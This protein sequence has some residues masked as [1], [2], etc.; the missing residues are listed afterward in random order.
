MLMDLAKETHNILRE[1]S[2]ASIKSEGMLGDK[3]VE[4][5]FGSVNAAELR[6]GETIASPAA[7]RRLGSLREGQSTSRHCPRFA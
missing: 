5:S 6:G 2:V 7:A 4:I 3:F 1:D